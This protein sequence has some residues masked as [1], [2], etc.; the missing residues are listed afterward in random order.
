[1]P[2]HTHSATARIERAP[3]A[4]GAS[5]RTGS[6]APT[7]AL[8][9]VMVRAATQADIDTITALRL[10]LLEEHRENPL[11]A[12]PRAALR[13]RA[14]SLFARQLAS[15]REITLLAFRNGTPVG[16]LRCLESEGYPLML[17]ARYG[18]LTSAYVCPEARR[19]GVLRHLVDDAVAWCRSRG[20]TQMRLHSVVHAADANGAWDA[21]GFAIAE[22]LR[23]RSIA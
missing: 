9:P 10:A 19:T 4:A 3:H 5:T 12:R 7:S 2:A 1:M 11:Y 17:P 23:V 22:H 13:A 16:M 21:L 6:A 20:L 8:P 15:P 18:Y 14:R